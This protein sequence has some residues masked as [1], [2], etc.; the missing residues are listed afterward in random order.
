MES[1]ADANAAVSAPLRALAGGALGARFRSWRG[2]SGRRYVF[3]VYD[4]HSCPTFEH[5]VALI[6]TVGRSG[7][8]RAIAVEDTGCFP[9]I[10][11]A[12]AAARIPSGDAC[13][14]HIHLLATSRTERAALIADLSQ[15]RRS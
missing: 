5:A 2:A 10:S 4:Q 7:E 8:R 14:V 13:E 3:S 9:D 12:K 11:L 1:F 15:A 6:A